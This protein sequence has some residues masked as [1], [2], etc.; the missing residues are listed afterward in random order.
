LDNNNDLLI[1][2]I[3]YNTS[4]EAEAVKAHLERT[5]PEH[6]YVVRMIQGKWHIMS[7]KSSQKNTTH[8]L[9][10]NEILRQEESG[11][12]QSVDTN[13]NPNKYNA[14]PSFEDGQR[15]LRE[16]MKKQAGLS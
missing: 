13:Q 1:E 9:N 10:M 2:R 8:S 14:F 15:K 4:Q 11:N 7:E 12:S 6:H 16:H 5:T 3:A